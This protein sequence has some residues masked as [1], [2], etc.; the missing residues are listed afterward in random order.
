M[1][2]KYAISSELIAAY[3]DGNVTQDEFCQVLQAMQHDAALRDVLQ[4]SLEVDA[5][6]GL[7]C[8]RNNT[9]P[10]TAMAATCQEENFCT[11]EC[12][13]YVLT[14]RAIDYDEQQL[15]QN[16]LNYGWLKESGTALHN[17]GRHLEH[18]GLVVSRRYN[19]SIEDIINALN[20][21]DDVIVAVDGGEL[22][23][24]SQLELL[25]DMY[26]GEKPDHTVVVKEITNDCITIFD[27]NSAN[28]QDLYSLSQFVNAWADSKNFMVLIPCDSDEY[29]PTP[30]DVSDVELAD[31]L[32]E[33]REAIAE[34]AHDIWAKERMR[35][36][37]RYG[38]QRNDQQKLHPCLVPYSKLPESEKEY[39][40]QMAMQTIKL[41]KKLGYELVKK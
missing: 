37:W 10:M 31:N 3:L 35:E 8:N 11:L 22:L 24:N 41:M 13:K 16:A 26:V 1:I 38:S 18:A 9:L 39:D 36:G 20:R 15:I 7:L 4:L 28:K 23:G 5:E 33:L 6:M 14:G 21:G 30:I 32:I 27:P 40:R 17:V 25:E 29:A 2:D 12:E 19:N 34:N